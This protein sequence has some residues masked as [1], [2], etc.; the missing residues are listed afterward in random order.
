MKIFFDESGQTGC[1]LPNKNG[2]LYRK[3]Q[4]FFVLAGIICKDEKEKQELLLKYRCFL[5]KYNITDKEF[6]GTDLLKEENEYI[7]VDF[8]KNM[9]DEQ[10]MYLC[11]YDKIFYLAS[12]ISM[13]FFD[14]SLMYN[15][16]I[17]YFTQQSALTR[18]DMSIFKE[19]C[20][21]L[22]EGT[23]ESRRQFIKYMVDYKYKMFDDET[24]MY[25]M[26]AKIMLD[27]YEGTE[28]VPEFPL[29]K[30]KGAYLNDNITNL[31]NLNALGEFVLAM[32]YKYNLEYDDIDICHDHIFEFEDEFRDT[33]RCGS[34]VFADSKDE[35]LLQYADNVASV[36]RRL[37]TE[38]T[39]LFSNPNP[40][41]SDKLYY[42]KKLSLLMRNIRENNIKFV[43]AI[44]DWVLPIAVMFQFDENTPKEKYN[45][46]DFMIL[47]CDIKDQVLM[48]IMS[49]DYDVE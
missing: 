38:T 35:L 33:L 3:N 1:V 8:I 31:I 25:K 6:K 18:E 9:I 11:C 26:Y 14:R 10:H 39:E 46:K 20:K 30:G 2:E 42:A 44:S 34:L 43:T 47:F 28:E 49:M 7:L 37:Y 41:K 45:N 13:Y 23:S 19:F 48:N 29:P 5:E 16:P 24:N 36:F 32:K 21:A 22:D 12:M 40:W 15:N 27:L 4:R 17:I